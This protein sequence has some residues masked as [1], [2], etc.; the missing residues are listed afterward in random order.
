MKK[1]LLLLSFLAAS[2]SAMANLMTNGDFETVDNR[3]GLVNN[4]PL[5]NLVP[6]RWDVYQTLPGWTT[7]SGRGIE[8]QATGV[9]V[10]AHSGKHYIELDSH[11]NSKLSG[12]TNAAM[13]Q[14]VLLGTG[15]YEISFYYR[16]RTN[17]LNDNVINLLLNNVNILGVN[18]RTSQQNAWAQFSTQFTV[19][20]QG[21]Q[22]IT[23]AADGTANQLGGFLDTVSLTKQSEI[24]AATPEPASLALMGGALVG[25]ALLRRRS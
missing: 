1:T 6:S 7:L 10:A 19:L 12:S 13:Y 20:K 18:S 21:T 25:L 9:V 2:H 23:F 4:R 16:P 8:V 22:R 14:D 5:N 15:N 17:S 11:P 24:A 3:L